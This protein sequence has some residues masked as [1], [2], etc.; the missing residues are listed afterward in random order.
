MLAA[1]EFPESGTFTGPQSHTINDMGGVVYTD[2]SFTSRCKVIETTGA[3]ARMPGGELA[4]KVKA[5]IFLP[6]SANAEKVT[7]GWKVN[8][9]GEDWNV[10]TAGRA[11]ARQAFGHVVR[12]TAERGVAA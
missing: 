9:W 6:A 7:S 5:V 11:D 10:R 4:S 3:E 2:Q 8:V 1:S 12:I